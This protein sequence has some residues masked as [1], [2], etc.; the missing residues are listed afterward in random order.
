M[1]LVGS[2]AL[3]LPLVLGWTLLTS[4]FHPNNQHKTWNRVLG[5]K[6]FYH[7]TGQLSV[8]QL[9]W[10]LGDTMD[11]YRDWMNTQK[12][13]LVIDELGEKARLLWIGQRRTDRVILYFHGGGYLLPMP[14]FVPDFWSYVLKE[15][16]VKDKEAGFAILQY[17]LVPTADFPTLLRQ[18]VLAAQ[19]LISTGVQPQNIQVVGDSAGANLI[20]ALLSHLLHPVPELPRL[21]LSAPLRG[22]YIM[23]PWV[24]LTGPHTGSVIANGTNDIIGPG[25]IET[26]GSLVL[27]GI[28]DHPH[29]EPYLEAARAPEGWFAGLD[30][31]VQRVLISGGDAERLRDSIAGFAD[32]IATH[33][34]KMSY[35]PQKHGVH[36]D[37]YFDFMLKGRPGKGEL[38]PI[39]VAWFSEGF[40]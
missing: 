3:H 11:V 21:T 34:Q 5:D 27:A 19:H 30:T 8:K 36:N 2:V 9:Q 31:V 37:P 12:L 16:K 15:L 18:A 40:E 4:P 32:L 28:R 23:S 29:L 33:H 10:A 14:F 1:G 20:V 6:V 25:C 22:A 13:P 7:L 39:I 24:A 38:T 35:V 17:S 26:W